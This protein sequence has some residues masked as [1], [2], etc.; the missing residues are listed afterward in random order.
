MQLVSAR[1]SILKRIRAS[2]NQTFGSATIHTS[3]VRE[4]VPP[5]LSIDELNENSFGLPVSLHRNSYSLFDRICEL[6]EGKGTSVF[7]A[8][9]RCEPMLSE[10][11]IPFSTSLEDQQIGLVE[12][13]AIAIET[14][15]LV[16]ATDGTVAVSAMASLPTLIFL[17]PSYKVRRTLN[18]TINALREEHFS[19]SNANVVFMHPQSRVGLVTELL[20]VSG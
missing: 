7:C 2:K 19:Q 11:G 8:S 1:E 18:R 6:W 10:N 3:P 16:L 14:G 9:E 4:T 12:L 5:S 20:V 17:C 13:S 15:H